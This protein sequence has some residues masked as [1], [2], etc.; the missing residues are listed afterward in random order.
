MG[1]SSWDQ[2]PTGRGFAHH[3]GFF[4]GE[5]D[6]YTKQYCSTTCALPNPN[7]T[8]GVCGQDFFRDRSPAPIGDPTAVGNYSTSLYR[9]EAVRAIERH[10]AGGDDAGGP[11]LFLYIAW[12]A[13]HVPLQP[14]PLLSL[15][16]NAT[17]G[18][19]PCAHVGDDRRSTYCRMVTA[20]DS[21]IGDVHDALR[22]HGLW[23][24]ALIFVTTDNGGSTYQ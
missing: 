22:H 5:S 23:D 3:V 2:T 12:Q 19:L 13:A 10:A 4:Q 1:Y 21:A 20:L 15:P 7:G 11:S 18:D 16:T 14:P 9:D 17:A 6:Y 8:R 24:D